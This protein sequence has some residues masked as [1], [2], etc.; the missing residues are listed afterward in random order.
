M[1][2]D[3]SS[4]LRQ[5]H[6]V[7][8]QDVPLALGD[9]PPTLDRVGQLSGILDREA[10]STAP[11]LRQTLSE[12]SR[13]GQEARQATLQAQALLREGSP[14]LISTLQEIHAL[15]A[16]TNR[17]LDLLVGSKL[18]GRSRSPVPQRDRLRPGPPPPGR[19]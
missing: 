13:T 14:V 5:R 1:R 19:P 7:A 9:F 18:G 8:G 10:A 17:L 6:P 12:A 16:T 11:R 3:F 2:I 15:T 4:T